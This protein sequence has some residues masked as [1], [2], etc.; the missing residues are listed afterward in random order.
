MEQDLKY[1]NFQ[2]SKSN[3]DFCVH[4]AQSNNFFS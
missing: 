3:I 2:N 4:Q 1:S